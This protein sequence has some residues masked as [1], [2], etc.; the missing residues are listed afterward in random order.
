MHAEFKGRVNV[1]KRLAVG[2]VEVACEFIEGHTLHGCGNERLCAVRGAGAYGVPE[3]DFETAALKKPGRNL[4]YADWIDVTLI[5][6]GE[7]AGDV[8]AN[9]NVRGAS[10]YEDG[11]EAVEAFG[12]GA[13]DVSLREG[14]GC[15]GEDGH[16]SG[17]GRERRLK[18]AQIGHQHRVGDSV[19][20]GQRAQHVGMIGHLRNPLW[21]NER[22]GLDGVQSGGREPLNELNLR[23]SGDDLLFVLQAVTRTDFDDAYAM[24]NG[25]VSVRPAHRDRSAAVQRPRSPDR[26]RR[27]GRIARG[28]GRVRGW[29]IPSSWPQ[30]P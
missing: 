12:D 3:R 4:R 13:V 21:G 29:C 1:G 8:A 20:A 27:N 16:F 9:R 30:A 19:P 11:R 2:V 28:P 26:P 7:S 15:R 17:S 6:T 18:A 23:G 22:R 25:H 24:R 5:G 14:F 10:S